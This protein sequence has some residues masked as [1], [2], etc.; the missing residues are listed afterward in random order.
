MD[1]TQPIV[2]ITGCSSGLGL[3]MSTYFTQKNC[4]V[5]GISRS[6]PPNELAF[7]ISAD[8]TKNEDR[9]KAH[10][11]I[12]AHF[13]RVDLLINN[14]GIGAYSTWEEL[15]EDE[16]R[17]IFEL[18]FF[19]V[20]SM[21]RLFLADL[22]ESNGTIINI[23]SAAGRLWI[24]C[25]GA[26]CAAKSA[27]S[28][29][30]NS[31][32]IELKNF[33]VRVLDVAPGQINTGFSSRSIGKRHPPEAPGAG[34]TSPKQMATAVYHAWRNQLK[35]ITYP[36]FLSLALWFVRVIIPSVYER[37]SVKLWKL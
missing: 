2:V 27:V 6:Q 37:I 12:M 18:D 26:Y 36:R 7:W 35:R 15:S 16:L 4:L 3:A 33:G 8:I 34:F 14:A 21:T 1:N 32:R 11:E 20:Y 23:S 19:A 25:M 13:G 10:Q 29:F 5:A 22:K 17:Q 9:K 30:S 24:P 28:M 31:L